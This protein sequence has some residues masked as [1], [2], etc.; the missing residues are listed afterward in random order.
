FGRISDRTCG[1]Y[2]AKCYFCAFD[3][4]WFNMHLYPLSSC[5][6]DQ[7][8]KQSLATSIP[9]AIRILK[10]RLSPLSHS[11]SSHAVDMV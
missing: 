10:F 8:V 1:R 9:V 11:F 6:V 4:A 5:L 2:N 3:N 7:L